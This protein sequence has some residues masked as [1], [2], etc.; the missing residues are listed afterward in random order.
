MIVNVDFFK[1]SGKWYS[2][3]EVDVG[4]ARLWKGDLYQAILANQ[5]IL[6]PGSPPHYYVVVSNP[7]WVPG[8]PPEEI[9]TLFALHLYKPSS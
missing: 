4:S 8:D 5:K 3:G 7:R 9:N 1:E 2:G 6:Q